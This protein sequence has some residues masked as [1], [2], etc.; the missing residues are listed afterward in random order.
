VQ[1]S[2]FIS[3]G[4]EVNS[5]AVANFHQTMGRL[6][7]DALEHIPKTERNMTAST[8]YISQNTYET[9][10]QKI[11]ELRQ[12]IL[13]LA[14]ADKNADRVYQANFQVF[15]VSRKEMENE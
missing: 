11:E 12:E 6:A 7:L 15:P 4:P 3:T 8:V 1:T 5:L 13:V 14:D 2:P 10:K 9:I